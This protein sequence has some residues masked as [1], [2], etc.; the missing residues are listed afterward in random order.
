M[1]QLTV[2]SGKGGTGK[3]TITAAL[4]D[5][6]ENKI[7]CDCDVDAANMH[8]LLNP[9]IKSEEDITASQVAL[10]NSSECTNCGLCEE[11]CRFD[12]VLNNMGSYIIAPIKCEGCGVCELVCPENAITMKDRVAGRVY[13]ADTKYG[14]FIYGKLIPGSGN[15][16]KIV[17]TIRKK[18]LELSSQ[19]NAELIL[20]DG[21]PG[22]G[23]PVISSI[24]G[25]N[26]ALIV[27][28][29]TL[30]GK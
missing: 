22:I 4:A 1:K 14:P 16:G 12:A 26:A 19:N 18:A 25:T 8:L 21:S 6:A 29:P 3:T 15:S 2:I 20:I 30:S 7:I 28:E 27:I 10:I 5:L 23:C 13:S 24:S 11:H 9:V 17:T